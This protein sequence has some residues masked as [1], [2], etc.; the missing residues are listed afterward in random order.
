MGIIYQIECLETGLVYIGRTIRTLK[1][2][3]A[4]HK[5]DFKGG[6]SKSA[7]EVL[8]NG[9]AFAS[10]IEIVDDE[11]KLDEREYYHIQNTECV[12]D[13]DGRSFD[14][15]KYM[16]KYNEEYCEDNKEQKKK[17]DQKYYEANKQ[18]ISE[19]ANEKINCPCGG[20]YTKSNK[21]RHERSQTHLDWLATQT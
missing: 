16:K 9:F 4:N 14:M 21:A 2:R 7:F 19:K 6:R 5:S 13:Y 17:S 8:K 1:Q 20:Q 12:N 10:V 15:K 3:F 18:V 11:N